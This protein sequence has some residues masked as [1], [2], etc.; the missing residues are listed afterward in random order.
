M[1]T[2][3]IEYMN[4]ECYYAILWTKIYVDFALKKNG[5]CRKNRQIEHM[6]TS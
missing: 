4:N 2:Y 5:K 6:E 1:L 3:E